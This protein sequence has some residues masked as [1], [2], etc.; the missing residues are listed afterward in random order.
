DLRAGR[1]ARKLCGSRGRVGIQ[2]GVFA[3]RRAGT[4][5]PGEEHLPA[6][7]LDLPSGRGRRAGTRP[8]LAAAAAA[9]SSLWRPLTVGFRWKLWWARR[10]IKLLQIARDALLQ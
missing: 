8:I 9:L 3:V 1:S 5:R 7:R 10:G 4:Y 2:T 6:R